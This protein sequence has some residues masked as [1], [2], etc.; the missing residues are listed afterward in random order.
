M[1]SPLV[2][3]RYADVLVWALDASRPAPLK[4]GDI[5]LVRFDLAALDL[6]RAVAA[7]LVDRGVH[8]LHRLNRTPGMELDFYQGADEAQLGFVAPGSAELHEALG[9]SVHLLAPDA[10]THLADID[11]RRIASVA[12][13]RKPLRDILERREQEGLFSWTLCLWPTAEL[14]AKAGLS[15]EDYADQVARACHLDDPDPVARWREALER[16]GEL[17]AWLD[18]LGATRLRVEA[19]GMDLEVTPG[20]ARRW[21]GLTGHNIPSFELYLSPDW[22]GTRGTYHADQPSYRGG[23]YVRGVRL[24]FEDGRV[25]RS[26]A[27]EGERFLHDQIAMDGGSDKLGEFSLTDRRF[28]A[29][30]RFM[31]MTLFD[32]N[33]GGAH[34][35]CHVALGASYP[36][37]YAGAQ[38]DLTPERRRELGFNSSALHWDLVNTGPKTVTATLPDGCRRVIYENGEF[39]L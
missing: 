27:E 9:A 11:P 28:S 25:V 18:G 17:R 29:I 31:A 10:L 1:F 7:R 33:Y 21:L 12:R 26:R 20:E 24:W 37:T 19:P 36:S 5:A 39:T 4:R 32:E 16:M 3:D 34:G 13:A 15:L 38:D 35:N 22:R 23:N 6:A 2:L 14:A 8:T 30:D